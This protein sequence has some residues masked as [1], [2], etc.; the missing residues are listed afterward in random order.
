[1]P[2]LDT[3]VQL[4]GPQNG[5]PAVN[6]LY[7]VSW[8]GVGFDLGGDAVLE[9]ALP[10]TSVPGF[11]A[12]VGGVY[13]VD[14]TVEIQDPAGERPRLEL[15]A[16]AQAR[17]VVDADE[18][19]IGSDGDAWLHVSATVLLNANDTVEVALR[20]SSVSGLNVCESGQFT[21]ARIG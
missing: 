1:M 7:Q 13:R 2:L 16:P 4:T 9:N 14:A 12:V 11:Q 15:L 10:D 18:P 19:Q 6:N 21:I 8:A 17:I 3:I 20:A 5:H